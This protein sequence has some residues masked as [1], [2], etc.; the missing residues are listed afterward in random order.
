M[1]RGTHAL[2]TGRMQTDRVCS[3]FTAA[4]N[5]LL[6]WLRRV[7]FSYNGPLSR[8]RILTQSHI[9]R[10]S[11]TGRYH[12]ESVQECLIAS[13]IWLFLSTLKTSTDK[14]GITLYHPTTGHVEQQLSAYHHHLRRRLHHLHH[15]RCHL[16]GKW[17]FVFVVPVERVKVTG[18]SIPLQAWTGP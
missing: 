10:Q 12:L 1:L 5:S 3:V 15:G 9:Q 7:E 2:Q 14:T 17:S 16:A 4:F 13:Y 6:S 18:K 8:I 11:M